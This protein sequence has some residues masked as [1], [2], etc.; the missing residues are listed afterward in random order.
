MYE[1]MIFLSI[2]QKYFELNNG[3]L[4][5]NDVLGFGWFTGNSQLLFDKELR[6]LKAVALCLLFTVSGWI[7]IMFI[8]IQYYYLFHEPT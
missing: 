3:S 7:P 4:F 8:A 2:V 1:K 5:L 6:L